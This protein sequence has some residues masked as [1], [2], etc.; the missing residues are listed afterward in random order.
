MRQVE[1]RNYWQGSM[2]DTLSVPS[3]I[4]LDDILSAYNRNTQ[5]ADQEESLV[6]Y[7]MD[8]LYKSNKFIPD[9]EQITL[10]IAELLN[11]FTLRKLCQKG[12]LDVYIDKDG[13]DSYGLTPL[14][15]QLRAEL[16]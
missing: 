2:S 6:Y 7:V 15:K 1:Y 10:R 5:T 14:G 8:E 11:G 16:G 9:T 4:E 13:E 12:V 3:Q